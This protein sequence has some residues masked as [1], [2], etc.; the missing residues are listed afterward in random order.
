MRDRKSEKNREKE[1]NQMME[2][3]TQEWARIPPSPW[4]P[5]TG[6]Q[7]QITRKQTS[8]FNMKQK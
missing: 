1:R 8:Y 5:L 2:K 4:N 6:S 3:K 7:K